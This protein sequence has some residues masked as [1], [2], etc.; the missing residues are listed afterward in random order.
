MVG[1]LSDYAISMINLCQQGK[2]SPLIGGHLVL[3]NRRTNI[4]VD[5]FHFGEPLAAWAALPGLPCE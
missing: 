2:S 4:I 5:I 3:L 1:Q